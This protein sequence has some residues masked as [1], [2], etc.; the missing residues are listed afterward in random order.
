LKS[1][2]S[3]VTVI[4]MAIVHL[5]RRQISDK[6]VMDSLDMHL[7]RSARTIKMHFTEPVTFGFFWFFNDRTVHA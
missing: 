5:M 7:G 4:S 3:V 1:Q 2:R 6:A